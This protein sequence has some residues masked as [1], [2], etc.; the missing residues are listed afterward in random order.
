MKARF[1][2]SLHDDSPNDP[3]A[4]FPR[5][6]SSEAVVASDNRTK[7]KDEDDDDEIEAIRS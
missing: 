5:L 2:S 6:V 7:A 4:S 3:V 1:T